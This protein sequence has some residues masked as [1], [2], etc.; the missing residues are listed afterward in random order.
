MLQ[1]DPSLSGKVVA[2]RPSQIKFRSH[3]Y[4]LEIAGT[5]SAGQAYLNRPLI[6]VRILALSWHSLY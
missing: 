2:L 1:V 5:F 4:A 3:V 6:K